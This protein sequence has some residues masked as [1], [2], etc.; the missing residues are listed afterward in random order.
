MTS[1]S[2]EIWDVK[3]GSAVWRV[4]NKWQQLGFLAAVT[5]EVTSQEGH[6]SRRCLMP[7]LSWFFPGAFQ[8][9]LFNSAGSSTL[10]EGHALDLLTISLTLYFVDT[11]TSNNTTLYCIFTSVKRHLFLSFHLH[12]TRLCRLRS[13]NI[14]H[15]VSL[16]SLIFSMKYLRIVTPYAM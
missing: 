2:L 7:V 10:F 1:R 8:A 3:V 14:H 16:L 12:F 11:N 6:L 4:T 13:F 5:A 9:V 15:A